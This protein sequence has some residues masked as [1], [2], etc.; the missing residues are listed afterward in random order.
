MRTTRRLAFL[1]VFGLVIAACSNSGSTVDVSLIEWSVTPT[2]TS[3]SSGEVMFN[4]TNNGGE[5]H[6]MVIVKDVAPEDLPTDENGHVVEEEIP[7]GTLIGEIA[8]FDAGTSDSAVF[9]LA[10]GTYTIFCNIVEDDEGVVESHF[11]NGM[12][13]TVEVTD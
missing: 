5:T 9:D 6:E 12:V 7:E 3:V 13:S 2:P 8:E 1:A 11:K 10:P 4:A